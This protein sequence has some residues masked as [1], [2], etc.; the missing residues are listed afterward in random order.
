MLEILQTGYT[1][2]RGQRKKQIKQI[3][4][5]S[6]SSQR[7]YL[8]TGTIVLNHQGAGA[9]LMYLLRR[10]W[11]RR[12]SIIV[13]LIVSTR[14]TWLH[15]VLAIEDPVLGARSLKTRGRRNGRQVDAGRGRREGLRPK[16]GIEAAAGN[17][18]RSI[19]IQRAVANG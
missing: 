14:H 16:A 5:V 18:A 19:L 13:I 12:R 17:T 7:G 1:R 11:R 3:V 9:Y 4:L 8:E 2:R 6:R 10:C 15:G